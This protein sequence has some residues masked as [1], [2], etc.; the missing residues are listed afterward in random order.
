MRKYVGLMVLGTDNIQRIRHLFPYYHAIR[1]NPHIYHVLDVGC[2]EGY[3]ASL[4]ARHFKRVT[5]ADIDLDIIKYARDKYF[6]QSYRLAFLPL[7][8]CQKHKYDMITCHQVIEHVDDPVSFLKML[9][10]M[11]KKNGKLQITTPNR[12]TRIGSKGKPFNRDH[13]DEYSKKNLEIFYKKAGFEEVNIYGIYA[14]DEIHEIENNR[15]R[16]SLPVKLAIMLNL[17]KLAP[18]WLHS[19]VSNMRHS[20]KRIIHK[21]ELKDFK[22][23]TVTAGS[24]DLMA[25]SYNNL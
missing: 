9:K 20:A 11:L 22:K 21:A 1:N 16:Q 6:N 10:N 12:I 3:G 24:L 2:G 8:T 18:D 4:M 23:S 19:T 7:R 5:G 13:V 15:I 17:H 25:I 14:T